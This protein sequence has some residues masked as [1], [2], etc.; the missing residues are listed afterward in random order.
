MS[1]ATVDRDSV[2]MIETGPSVVGT[3]AVAAILFTGCMAMW[4]TYGYLV[5]GDHSVSSHGFAGIVKKH[6]YGTSATK[7][8]TWSSTSVTAGDDT[9]LMRHGMVSL[10]K[11]TAAITDYGLLC[12][13]SDDQTVVVDS[14]SNTTYDYIVGKVVGKIGTTQVIVDLDDKVL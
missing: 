3:P 4:D 11:A 2:K 13:I 10:F 8:T 14:G 6:T 12:R 7:P 9:S 5:R 1:H